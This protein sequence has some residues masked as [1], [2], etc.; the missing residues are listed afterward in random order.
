MKTGAA[1]AL[2]AAK[3]L[4]IDTVHIGGPKADD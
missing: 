4:T 3:L 1:A 2:E